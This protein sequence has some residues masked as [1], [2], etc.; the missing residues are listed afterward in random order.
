MSDLLIGDGVTLIPYV[1]VDGSRVIPDSLVKW[2]WDAAIKDGADRV[3]F[4][5]EKSDLDRLVKMLKNPRNYPVFIFRTGGNKPV[6]I[7]WVNGCKKNYAFS[8]FFFLKETWGRE[9]FAM[10]KALTHYWLN[11]GEPPLFDVLIGNIASVNRNAIRFVERLGWTVIGEIPHMANGG[12]MTVTHM[13]RDD[14]F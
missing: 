12:A 11:F 3:L 6:G 13:E 4:A 2:F 5:G 10:G 8:H 14:G 9:S 1:E 7:G